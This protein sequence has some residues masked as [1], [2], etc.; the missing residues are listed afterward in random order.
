MVS[1][2][3][4]PEYL[5]SLRG[6]NFRL[7]FF[8]QSVSLLGS[9]IQQV[10]LVW[11]VYRL[12]GSA[13]L[14][15]VTT[16][17]SLAPQLFLGPLAGAWIDRQDKRRWLIGV[18]ALL[19]VQ[20]LVLAVLT[21]TG[22]IGPVMIIAMSFLLGVLGSFD[23]PLR[24]TLISAYVEDRADLPNALALNSMLVNGGRFFGPPIAGL[25]LGLTSEAACFALNALSFTALVFAVLRAEGKMPEPARGSVGHVFKEGARYVWDTWFVRILIGVVAAVNITASSYA[26]LLPILAK[27]I[28]LG[29]AQTLGW[30]WGAAGAGAFLGTVVLVGTRSLPRLSQGVVGAVALSAL[31]LGVVAS[32]TSLAPAFAGLAVLGFGITVC[33]A[34]IN[35]LLQ[36]C[37][38]ETLRGRVVAFFMA[39]RFGFDAI[40][41]LI[42]GLLAALLGVQATL[43]IEGAV[44][45]VCL[46]F[47]F[48]HRQRLGAAIEH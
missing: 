19:A 38:P 1:D 27:D 30:L 42:G 8:G 23:A 2:W 17:V 10:A 41:G 47:L 11:L 18:Q 35:M 15:G 6:R 13:A 45:S 9:W 48:L 12:T 33:N 25:L 20:A 44:L 24:H 3:R 43:W 29:D 36:S 31:A 14:L 22:L 28:F 7:Y 46:V 5:R 21:A 37:T 32:S 34:G 39:T 26:T 16:F 40:G 4:V